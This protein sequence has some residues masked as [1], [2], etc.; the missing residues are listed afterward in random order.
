M[1]GLGDL[2]I[3]IKECRKPGPVNM[4]V[5]NYIFIIQTYCLLLGMSS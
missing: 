5:L 1:P 4:N 3:G 2:L